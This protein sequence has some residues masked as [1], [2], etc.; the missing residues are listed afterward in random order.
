MTRFPIAAGAALALLAVAGC[1]GSDVGRA[2]FFAATPTPGMS[3]PDPVPLDD[4]TVAKLRESE[5]PLILATNDGGEVLATFTQE[6]KEGEVEVWS[7]P[8][9][10]RMT[11]RNGVLV[12]SEQVGQDLLTVEPAR[13]VRELA[14]ERY[15]RAYHHNDGARV[16]VT[17]YDCTMVE[18]GPEE[19][20]ILDVRLATLRLDESCEG[21]GG[22]AVEN[23]F[24]LASDGTV[25]QSRQWLNDEIGSIDLKRLIQ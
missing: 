23:A 6:V 1:S 20:D 16:T 17:A 18:R 19:V 21:P 4:L 24:W 11:F 7:S 14:G 3:D 25:V 5:V 22:A 13:P 15:T 10:V 12:G 2:Q 8:D 9:G